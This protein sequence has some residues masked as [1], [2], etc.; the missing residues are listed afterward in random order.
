MKDQ[1]EREELSA[2]VRRLRREMRWADIKY[3]LLSARQRL[4][5]R[6]LC[7]RDAARRALAREKQTC[8]RRM[9]EWGPWK[10]ERNLDYWRKVGPDRTCSFCGS[11][12]PQDF[13]AFLQRVIDEGDDVR[14]ERSDKRY[15]IYL[16]RPGISNAFDGA[17]KFYTQHLTQL[18]AATMSR[19][20][21]LFGTAHALSLEKWRRY[22][23]VQ[24][25]RI[26]ARLKETGWSRGH[27]GPHVEGSE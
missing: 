11:M 9:G 26:K 18:D 25:E 10:K 15:K 23:E 6:W 14:L 19:F 4:F 3:R 17:I 16:H 8:P 22:H 20:E 1:N 7:L 27:V 2:F 5:H 13:M 21:N 12:H 24:R